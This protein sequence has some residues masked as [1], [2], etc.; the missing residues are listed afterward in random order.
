MS[1][2]YGPQLVTNGDF[3]DHAAGW[4]NVGWDLTTSEQATL[5]SLRSGLFSQALAIESG[6]SYL[7]EFNAIVVGSP[8]RWGKLGGQIFGI[9]NGASSGVVVAGS[10]D[11]LIQFAGQTGVGMGIAIDNISVK[12]VISE[13]ALVS[14]DT[15]GVVTVKFAVPLGH[16]PGDYCVLHANNGAGAIDWDTPFSTKQT[17]LFPGGSGNYGFGMAPFA[18]SPFAM[19]YGKNLRRGFA[20]CPFA[21][22]PF[23]LGAVVI[24]E[25][26]PVSDC[27][28]WIFG[29][30][31]YDKLGN[32]HTGTPNTVAAPVHVA[33]AVP[34][35][36]KKDS[37]DKA[38]DI[39]TLSVIDPYTQTTLGNPPSRL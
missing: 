9:T 26:V 24:T 39:L 22:S 15:I 6:Y 37:Y 38:T 11:T 21:M 1:D 10:E 31:C 13:G 2:S 16:L 20:T 3:A 30:K 7:L 28:D 5:T 36:L 27:G 8:T 34:A 23:G 29:V 33:P 18:M 14:N 25:R 35:G 12:L 19:P 17:P 4:S 32:E